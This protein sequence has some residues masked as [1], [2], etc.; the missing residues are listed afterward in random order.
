[1]AK[2]VRIHT[3]GG[4]EVLQIEDIDVGEPGEGEVRIQVE[5]VGL[6][7]SEAMSRVPT[8][9]VLNPHAGLLGAAAFA[10]QDARSGALP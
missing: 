10:L 1:M 3:L 7:L 9:A 6:N 4:P 5:A 2:V 8:V